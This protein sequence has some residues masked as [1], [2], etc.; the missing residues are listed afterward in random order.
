MYY[1]YKLEPNTL[2]QSV[3]KTVEQFKRF[4]DKAAALVLCYVKI[5]CSKFYLTVYDVSFKHRQHHGN[6]VLLQVEEFLQQ[7]HL[8][9]MFGQLVLHVR[10][11]EQE[12]SDRVP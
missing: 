7:V 10:E 8:R 12:T 9:G 5:H 11:Q 2:L 6:H 4:K 1:T 3:L